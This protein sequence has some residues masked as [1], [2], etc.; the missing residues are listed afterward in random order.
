MYGRGCFNWMRTLLRLREYKP[1]LL[2]EEFHDPEVYTIARMRLT[3]F[4]RDYYRR[5]WARYNALYPAVEVA[6]PTED[7]PTD[8]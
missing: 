3:A 7:A 2:I 4:G 8:A 6:R 1:Q 5:E